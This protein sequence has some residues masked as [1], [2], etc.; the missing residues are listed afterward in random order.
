MSEAAAHTQDGRADAS[1]LARAVADHIREGRI[2]EAELMLVR[3]HECCP[4]SRD[5]LAFPVLIALQRGRTHDAWQ[6][7]NGLPDEQCPELKALCL[8]MLGD[9]LWHGYASAHADSPNPTVRRAMRQ[10]LGC[11]AEPHPHAHMHAHEAQ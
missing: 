11:E 8:R 6:L 1:A 9:P 5:V 7:V 2:D 4:A 10:L 3:L